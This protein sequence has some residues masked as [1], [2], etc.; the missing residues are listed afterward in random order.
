MEGESEDRVWTAQKQTTLLK[1]DTTTLFKCLSLSFLFL[2]S[3]ISSLF[4]FSFTLSIT[5]HR[6][7]RFFGAGVGS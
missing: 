2:S 4:I 7:T 6:V 5:V 3:F 1:T